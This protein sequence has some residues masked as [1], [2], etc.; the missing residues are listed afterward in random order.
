MET[1]TPLPS[2]PHGISAPQAAASG[3]ATAPT[4]PAPPLPTALQPP[5]PPTCSPP[6]VEVLAPVA[7]GGAARSGLLPPPRGQ[8]PPLLLGAAVVG[9]L[10]AHGDDALS[11]KE[12][13]RAGAKLGAVELH[14]RE[15][16]PSSACRAGGGGAPEEGGARDVPAPARHGHAAAPVEASCAGGRGGVG[17]GGLPWRLGGGTQAQARR[18]GSDE[19]G[20]AVWQTCAVHSQRERRG[21]RTK[22]PIHGSCRTSFLRYVSLREAP[23][24]L[25]SPSPWWIVVRVYDLLDRLLLLCLLLLSVA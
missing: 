16:R 6:S 21:E 23:G 11:R 1:L 10:L 2:T 20:E 22:P 15:P 17:T 12:E 4:P 25:S 24:A 3:S 13:R 7:G 19:P 18:C 9:G 14:S 8:P 5:T